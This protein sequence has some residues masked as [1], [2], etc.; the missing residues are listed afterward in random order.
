MGIPKHLSTLPQI[1]IV[2]SKVGLQL[3]AAGFDLSL[4]V[5]SN[6]RFLDL[7]RIVFVQKLA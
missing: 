6:C 1:L 5:F 2:K 4:A 7:F 3:V